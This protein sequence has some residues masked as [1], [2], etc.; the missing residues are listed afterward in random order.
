MRFIP[1]NRETFE[2]DYFSGFQGWIFLARW[3]PPWPVHFILCTEFPKSAVSFFSE[4][5][6]NIS[7]YT[8][9][10]SI[11]NVCWFMLKKLLKENLWYHQK[12][13]LS[14]GCVMS[15]L[16]H[17]CQILKNLREHH[18]I[19]LFPRPERRNHRFTRFG[20][21]EDITAFLT[22]WYVGFLPGYKHA[23]VGI[24]R[25]NVRRFYK[26]LECGINISFFR[27]AVILRHPLKSK[28]LGS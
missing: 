8:R 2:G 7:L 4:S 11:F 15:W 12:W 24:I 17:W 25:Q 5:L 22:W 16:S 13:R 18:D 19:T 10:S 6:N 26:I 27:F 3:I 28:V 20:R 1:Y 23:W 21:T 9:Q 14:S